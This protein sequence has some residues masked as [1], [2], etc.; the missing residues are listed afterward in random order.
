[1]HAGESTVI[2]PA[3]QVGDV[4][5]GRF[6][7]D[8]M[9]GVGG[10]GIVVAATHL[11]LRQQVAVKVMRAEL[12]RD[13]T[14]ADR[15]L[16]EARAAAGLRTD[17][18]CRVFDIGRTEEGLP[19]IVMELLQGNDLASLVARAPLP[20]GLAVGYVI[21]ACAAVAEAHARG[22]IHRDLKPANLFVVRRND[23]TALVKVLDFG[24]A[25]IAGELRLTHSQSVLGSTGYMSPEQLVAPSQV[26]ARTDIWALGVTLYQLISGRMP[27]PSSQ[28]AEF[29]ILVTT[30]DPAPLA[31]DP[32]LAAVIT[33][34]LARDRD[35]RFPGVTSL[36]DALAPFSGSRAPVP[37]LP[38]ENVVGPS[39]PTQATSAGA[40]VAVRR[41]SRGRWILAGLAF[42][43]GV[44][45]MAAGVTLARRSKATPV[46]SVQADAAPPDASAPDAAVVAQVA[47]DAAVP[48]AP[49][50][51][52][53]AVAVV[54]AAP[55]RDARARRDV[56]VVPDKPIEQ[57]PET[58]RMNEAQLA[59]LEAQMKQFANDPETLNTVY[60]SA[61]SMAC[62]LGKVGKAKAYIAKITD[63]K[64]R[65][66]AAGVCLGLDIE[67]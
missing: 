4:I 30:T 20:A 52:A 58:R 12:A 47:V 61:V 59:Q 23:G 39:I 6:R 13:Q 38:T 36:V 40:P 3:V 50:V 43:A 34:C 53:V 64:L 35:D 7:V 32:G 56:A 18:V 41:S 51:D 26:D 11:E 54:D 29:T 10:M 63:R 49:P 28:L 17:H 55:P 21:Q 1:V 48:A 24:V 65:N 31:I 57:D 60:T 19:Y 42:V 62:L 44:G 9:I 66:S 8:R 15:F 27:F 22:V 67:L 37:A 46:A 45:G 14:V 16:H 2:L 33:R 5:A 25:K